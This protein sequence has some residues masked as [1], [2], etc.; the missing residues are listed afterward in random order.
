MHINDDSMIYRQELLPDKDFG[1][2]HENA[3][4]V[5]KDTFHKHY[6]MISSNPSTLIYK[7][8]NDPGFRDE[9]ISMPE[10]VETVRIW[11]KANRRSRDDYSVKETCQTT[12]EIAR[13]N[14]GLKDADSR[15]K[16]LSDAKFWKTLPMLMSAYCDTWLTQEE[17]E[18]HIHDL[19]KR[20]I[21]EKVKWKIRTFCQARRD[22]LGLANNK[23]ILDDM[24]QEVYTL[25]FA[26]K[27]FKSIKKPG[28]LWRYLQTTVEHLFSIAQPKLCFTESFL[29]NGK[30]LGEGEKERYSYAHF[31]IY[32]WSPGVLENILRNENLYEER[33]RQPL[34]TLIEKYY[35]PEDLER[36]ARDIAKYNAAIKNELYVLLDSI[37]KE[38]AEQNKSF[39][40]IDEDDLGLSYDLTSRESYLLTKDK[41]PTMKRILTEGDE[42][43]PNP[44]APKPGPTP[45]N[46]PTPDDPPAPVSFT[47][48]EALEIVDDIFGKA[49]KESEELRVLKLEM[50]FDTDYCEKNKKF[51]DL[52]KYYAQR[53]ESIGAFKSEEGTSFKNY[54]SNL[55]KKKRSIRERFSQG[56]LRMIENDLISTEEVLSVIEF[57]KVNNYY[58]V[59]L[60][61]NK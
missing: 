29:R 57:F 44:P 13:W 4:F 32:S 18:A 52:S 17:G 35:D 37:R 42:P 53:L 12:Y 26:K 59:Y 9:F 43:D 14:A 3:I 19:L 21:P 11:L 36:K 41:T 23:G 1:F 51:P 8:L 6:A 50:F 2:Y 48:M 10:L 16:D 34:R 31:S 7:L 20:I 54:M 47:D 27:P 60:K 49:P 24:C 15:K 25:L 61:V 46:P 30:T 5:G 22:W 56:A 45:D 28:T 38:W 39:P 58:Q 55:Y 33:I 40:A